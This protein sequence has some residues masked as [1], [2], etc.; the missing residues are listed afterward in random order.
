[1]WVSPA[2]RGTGTGRRLIDEII[3]W[4]AGGGASQLR[5]QV[6]PDN[7]PAIGLYERSGFSQ[8]GPADDSAGTGIPVLVMTRPLRRRPD[9]AGYAGRSHGRP[10]P[11]GG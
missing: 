5:L 1:M 2:A 11:V 9:P 8:A 3:T 7:A 6:R 10:P 4:A